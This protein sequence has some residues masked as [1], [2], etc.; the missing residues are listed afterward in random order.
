MIQGAIYRGG[1]LDV[2]FLERDPDSKKRGYIANSYLAVL[3][4][5]IP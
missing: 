2:V 5:Q 1:R 3:R 4:E